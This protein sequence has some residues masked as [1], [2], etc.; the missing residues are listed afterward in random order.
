MMLPT[1][2][3]VGLAIATPLLTL[4]PDL[5]PAAL[6]GGL[7]GGVF[8]DLDLYSGHRKTLHFPT[9]YVVAALPAA[10]VAWL[11]PG[12][13]TIAAVFFVFGAVAHCR[14]DRYGG[15]LELEPWEATSDRAV[16]DHARGEWREP[17]RWVRYDGSPRD[18]LL[19][20]AVAVPLFLTVGWPFRGVVGLALLV[21]VVYVVLRQRLAALA[22]VVFGYVP[23]WLAAHVP[24]RYQ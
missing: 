2:A 4:A 13:V 19:L 16:Y 23:G 24:D 7:L 15:G 5:A 22:P 14:M 20:T 9:G 10:A 8:P 17:K 3:V 12:H 6:T 21:G 1:H 18:L 11:A